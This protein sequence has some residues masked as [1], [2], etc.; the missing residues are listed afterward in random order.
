MT[1]LEPWPSGFGSK[2]TSINCATTTSSLNDLTHR[3]LKVLVVC[4]QSYKAIYARKLRLYS[5]NI[6]NFLVSAT[7]Q[8]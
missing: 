7:L 5:H 3:A 8:S 4:G 1:G 2:P 6:S